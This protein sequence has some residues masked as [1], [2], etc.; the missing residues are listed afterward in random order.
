MA[1]GFTDKQ[2]ERIASAIA[3]SA[4]IIA[5]DTDDEWRYVDVVNKFVDSLDLNGEQLKCFLQMVA[6]SEKNLN[7]IRAVNDGKLT[8]ADVDWSYE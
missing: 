2:L 4:D 8:V 1:V 3:F 6:V 7:D 5:P